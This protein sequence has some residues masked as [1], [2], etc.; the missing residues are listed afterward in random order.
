MNIECIGLNLGASFPAAPTRA[1]QAFY[2]QWKADLP[3]SG[4][5]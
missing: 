4:I 5:A 2:G 1:P 3:T